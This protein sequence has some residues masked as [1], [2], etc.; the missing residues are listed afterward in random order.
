[1]KSRW[2]YIVSG[3]FII[4]GIIIVIEPN[5][6]S[7][8][9]N[10]LEWTSIILFSIGILLIFYKAICNLIKNTCSK[11]SIRIILSLI[12][13]TLVVVKMFN[14]DLV[15]DTNSIYLIL[16]SIIIIV[17]P[18]LNQV[19]ERVSKVKTGELELEFNMQNL[20]NDIEKVEKEV[21]KKN[22]KINY[23]GIDKETSDRFKLV[24]S[25]PKLLIVAIGMEIEIRLRK[26]LSN[27][28]GAEYSMISVE[29]MLR[30]ITNKGILDDSQIRIYRE[31]KYIRNKV[32]HGDEMKDISY[33][34]LCE[35]A[36]L[37]I[38]VLK[39]IPTSIESEI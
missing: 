9:V 27:T 29:R 39:T 37:G 2:N 3:I 7:N 19:I 15:I 5:L 30:D 6:I 8:V 10:K 14:S 21:E 33:E 18:D 13:V 28:Y 35:F 26:L 24:S 38:R 32:V 17:I 11:L 4:L 22:N 20:S 25:D 16:I 1:M 31:F 23:G 34:Q 36:D 12:C